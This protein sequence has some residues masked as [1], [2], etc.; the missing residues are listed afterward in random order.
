MKVGIDIQSTIGKKTGIGYYTTHL[1]D[2]ISSLEGVEFNY[3]SD[4]G[5]LELNSINR[6][7]WEN[8]SLMS[9][10]EKDDI[11]IFHIPGFAGPFKKGRHKRVTT[12]HDL[13]G[14][15]FPE[16][17]GFLSRFYWQKWLPMCIKKSDAIIAVSECTKGDIVR[18]LGVPDE[19]IHVVL[20]AADSKFTVIDDKA[21]LEV[22]RKK[23]DLPEEFIL[24]VGS[25]EPRKNIHGLIEAFDLYVKE[26]G[27]NINLVIVGSKDWGYKKAYEEA[28]KRG[29]LS[30]V[31]F[32]D[33]VE[34]E[35]LSG[36][37]NLSKIFVLPSFYEGFGLP[38]LE[39]M[40]C[41]KPVICSGVSALPEITEDAAILV[42]PNSTESIKEAMEKVDQNIAL[43]KELS[44]K[45]IKRA[46]EFSWRKT[47][48]DTL[49]VYEKVC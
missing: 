37:Y 16:N 5:K 24:T 32:T 45:A 25:V 12:V 8:G 38:V 14:I 4:P 18:L 11:D 40:A 42:D 47:A 19:K 26:S 17:L 34:D 21:K 2:K 43:Q 20:S 30:R 7:R 29:I 23:Y 33:Y 22:L 48:E 6:M 41:G 28:E 9:M 1:L 44:L 15:L 31:V 3:Y 10:A 36:I 35:D 46:G 39:A 49:K 27:S 13:I